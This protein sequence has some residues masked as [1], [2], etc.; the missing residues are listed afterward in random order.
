MF[1]FACCLCSCIVFCLVKPYADKNRVSFAVFNEAKDNTL[2]YE[3]AYFV[4]SI[5]NGFI[6]LLLDLGSHFDALLFNPSFEQEARD[7]LEEYFGDSD[8]FSESSED[9]DLP[10]DAATW[11]DSESSNS[12]NEIDDES[13]RAELIS[14]SKKF[15]Q[16][17]PEGQTQ[18]VFIRLIT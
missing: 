17:L 15:Q 4:G 14:R 10:L 5:D 7:T 3:L 16:I 11:S 6:F 1:D 12:S 9:L 18:V 8:D 2:F 13:D